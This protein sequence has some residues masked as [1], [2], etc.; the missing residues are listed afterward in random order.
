MQRPLLESQIIL[1]V[2][3]ALG[4]R[5]HKLAPDAGSPDFALSFHHRS[6]Q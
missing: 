1:T 6:F 4:A 2:E 5:G 3:S